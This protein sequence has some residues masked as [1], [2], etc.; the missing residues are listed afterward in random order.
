M[1]APSPRRREIGDGGAYP[2]AIPHI[3][4]H[5]ADAQCAGPIVIV[6]GGMAAGDRFPDKRTRIRPEVVQPQPGDRDQTVGP[7]P[8]VSEI[9]VGLHGTE[10]WQQLLERPPGIPRGRPGVVVRRV[11]T[12][13]AAGRGWRGLECSAVDRH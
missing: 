10:Q 7:V 9:G 2:H 5:R 13:R 6:V 8:F 1:S 4:R 3:A 12:R 11:Q